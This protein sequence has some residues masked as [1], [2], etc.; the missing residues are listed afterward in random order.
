M[1]VPSKYYLQYDCSSQ[2]RTT[3]DWYVCNYVNLRAILNF[4]PRGEIRPLGGMFTPLFAPRGE[5]SYNLEE[6]RGKQLISPPGDN[7]T[8][9]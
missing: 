8:P 5:C 6:W 7:F 2:Y 9:R 1:Y 4:T 3:S